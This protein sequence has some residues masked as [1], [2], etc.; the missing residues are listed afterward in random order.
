MLERIARAIHAGPLAVPE[1][2]D[3]I[4]RA[5]G[6]G[7]DALCAQHLGGAKFFVDGRH[8]LDTGLLQPVTLL[9]DHLVHHAQRRSAVAA[10]EAP[11]VPL[12]AFVV[13][14]LHQ[15]QAHQGLCARQKHR[16]LGGPDVVLELV[17]AQGGREGG[18]RGNGR[19]GA[20]HETLQ[21]SGVRIDL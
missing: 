12:L 1:A 20:G 7:L 8:E 6:V 3:P 11:G 14:A 13:L 19:I 4:H 16:A 17:V 9:P 21:S 15:H 2:E 5:L 18:G 10:D